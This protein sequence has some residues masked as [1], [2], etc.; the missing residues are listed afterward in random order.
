MCEPVT[1]HVT[2]SAR[3]SLIVIILTQSAPRAETPPSSALSA[4]RANQKARGV[5]GR[6]AQNGP[7]I[8]EGTFKTGSVDS[9]SFMCAEC[10]LSKKSANWVFTQSDEKPR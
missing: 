7:Q 4:L 9:G 5:E 1:E 6:D 8:R 10:G 3:A 2:L